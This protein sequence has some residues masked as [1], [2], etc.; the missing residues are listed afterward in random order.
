MTTNDMIWNRLLI[1]LFAWVSC[2]LALA[3]DLD[4]ENTLNMPGGTVYP[5]AAKSFSYT[6]VGAPATNVT[7]AAS[8]STTFAG[9]TQPRPRND[10]L[11][12]QMDFA[13]NTN[14]VTFTFTFS[15][16]VSNLSFRMYEVDR[17]GVN[18]TSPVTYNYVDQVTISGKVGASTV[19]PAIG[20]AAYNT[21][22][23]ANNN[24]ITGAGSATSTSSN[25]VVFSGFVTELTVTYCNAPNAQALPSNQSV[26]IGDM[27]WSGPL[28]VVL[29]GFSGKQIA[30]QTVLSWQTSSEINSQRFDVERSTDA[31]NF[32]RLGA[33]PSV[34][35]ARGLQNYSF[36][37]LDPLPDVGYYRLKQWDNDGIYAYSNVISVVFERDG[38]YLNVTNPVQ[39]G[40]FFLRTNAPDFKA[41]LYTFLGQELDLQTQPVGVHHYRLS[42]QHSLRGL[43]V[44]RILAN[45]TA[46]SQKLYFEN[47]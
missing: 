9:T 39:D 37:D 6:N 33:V 40:A 19:Y 22:S 38:F 27:S 3:Q 44:L 21:V 17:G 11:Q 35:E 45:G 18:A 46:H 29:A 15:P 2:Q 30:N 25:T 47:Y 24:V 31:L 20:T 26:T 12:S 32:E 4:F 34:G 14:C 36:T 10:G 7:V 42:T 41:T 16:G 13:T 8:G 43:Y 5:N 1:V 28:P 23:G